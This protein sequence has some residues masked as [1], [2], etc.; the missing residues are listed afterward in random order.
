MPYEFF[1][2]EVEKALP[3]LYAQE[4]LGEQAMV[5][6]KFFTPD[7]NWTWYAT[8]YDP[9][10]RIF[11]GLVVGFETELGYFSLGELMSATGPLGLHIERDIHWKPKTIAEIRELHDSYERR[12]V[13]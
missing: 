4:H 7:S 8:E 2:K 9:A 11:F 10:E 5:H 6:A 1:P 13:S 12:R 3:P